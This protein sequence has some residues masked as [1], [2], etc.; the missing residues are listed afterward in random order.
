MGIIRQARPYSESERIHFVPS[1][2][3]RYFDPRRDERTLSDLNGVKG[4]VQPQRRRREQG[5]TRTVRCRK[6]G[7]LFTIAE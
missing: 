2:D 5:V 6:C 4:V 7:R 1:R 3:E